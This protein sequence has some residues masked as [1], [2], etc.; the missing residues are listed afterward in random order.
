MLGGSLRGKSP[1]T[2]G[3]KWVCV[4]KKF[5]VTPLKC[6]VFS[7][8]IGGDWSFEDEVDRKLGC[9]VSFSIDWFFITAEM[10][11][12]DGHYPNP[13]LKQPKLYKQYIRR[14]PVAASH[15]RSMLRVPLHSERRS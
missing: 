13:Q 15:Y 4:D 7:F 8:G 1:Y 12:E 5:K 11:K 9:K 14:S 3:E 10:E 2:D 6:L